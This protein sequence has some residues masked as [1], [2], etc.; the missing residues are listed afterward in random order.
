LTVRFAD[1]ALEALMHQFDEVLTARGYTRTEHGMRTNPPSGRPGQP[2]ARDW[3]QKGDGRGL[4]VN[5]MADCQ[6]VITMLGLGVIVSSPERLG[7]I[8]DEQEGAQ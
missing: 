8:L 7:Q 6:M 1:P 4:V 3:W 2:V 5:M